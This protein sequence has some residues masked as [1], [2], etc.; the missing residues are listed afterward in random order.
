MV[1]DKRYKSGEVKAKPTTTYKRENPVRKTRPELDVKTSI[2]EQIERKSKI[3]PEEQSN[4]ERNLWRMHRNGDI[5][6]D[7][8]LDIK[9]RL[10][11]KTLGPQKVKK[12]FDTDESKPS[13]FGG[14]YVAEK[15]EERKV[16]EKKGE[17]DESLRQPGE[18]EIKGKFLSYLMQSKGFRLTAFV[19][20]AVFLIF[21]LARTSLSVKEISPVILILVVLF[22]IFLFGYGGNKEKPKSLFS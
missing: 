8:Y 3:T 20:L 17:Q 12:D 9:Q 11:E 13:S 2:K 16:E 6:Y 7:D 10:I 22:I 14:D 5:S 19:V 21:F 1:F 15:K 4:F 18:K